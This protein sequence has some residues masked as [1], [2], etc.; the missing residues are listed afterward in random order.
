MWLEKAAR[1]GFTHLVVVRRQPMTVQRLM[2]YPVYQEGLL[3][4]LFALVAPSQRDHL[5]ASALISAR[6][7]GVPMPAEQA[8]TCFLSAPPL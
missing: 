6:A 3:E 1:A 2:H 8:N 7:G 4:N 5:V